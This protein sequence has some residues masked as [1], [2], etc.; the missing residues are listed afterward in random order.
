MFPSV[1]LGCSSTHGGASYA[2]RFGELGLI[3]GGRSAYPSHRSIRHPPSLI[4]HIPV[5][6]GTAL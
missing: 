2:D 5:I 6:P 4:V 1:G 3:E